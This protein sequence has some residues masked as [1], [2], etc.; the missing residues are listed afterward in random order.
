MR[1]RGPGGGSSITLPSRGVWRSAG[2]WGRAPG[3][4]AKYRCRT[5]DRP[6]AVISSRCA[7]S[8]RPWRRTACPPAARVALA[9]VV[10][11]H[12]RKRDAAAAA[13]SPQLQRR[14]VLGPD[15]GREE[16]SRKLV[17]Q[18]RDAI[19]SPSPVQPAQEI[20]V[21]PQQGPHLV[22][23]SLIARQWAKGQLWAPLQL[24]GQ[25]HRIH[26]LAGGFGLVSLPS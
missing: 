24:P 14:G 1:N 8:R 20:L 21:A 16:E 5:A 10:G 15:A 7:V 12:Q 3:A 17:L 22:R 6:S 4:S 13:P 11:D 9:L 18:A 23:T 2:M 26:R 19:R 25:A